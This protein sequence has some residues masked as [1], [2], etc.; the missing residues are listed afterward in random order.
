MPEKIGLILEGGAMRGLFTAGALDELYARH[1]RFAGIVGVSAGAVFG[2]NYKSHQPGR[3]LRYNLRFCR[4]W[5][6]ASVWSWLLTGNW[7]GADFCYRKIPLELDMFDAA[8][9]AAD[10]TEFH[11]VVTDT[12]TGQ[13]VYRKCDTADEE[14]FLWMRASASMPLVS[15]PVEIAGRTYLD[16]ALSDAIPLAF[17]ER[18]G[19]TRNV[20]ILTRPPDYVKGPDR[21]LKFWKRLFRR[22]PAVYRCLENR[23]LM[24]NREREYVESARRA[25]RALVISPE[26]ALPIEK[27]CRD[28]EVLKKV[29]DLGRR[30]VEDRSRE[31]ASFL[32]S[33]FSD[34]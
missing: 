24:Y 1:H 18:R 28:R 33:S 15:R 16:G 3:V 21:H 10:P 20:V 17:A 7:F 29:Y 23:H 6:Y 31:I 5:R 8:A 22:S 13:S 27:L 2:C 9:F 26:T 19:F 32:A 12:A 4:D 30:A 34:A 14:C 25:G 11:L